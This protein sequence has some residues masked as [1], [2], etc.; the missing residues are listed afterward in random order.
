MYG[1]QLL[2]YGCMCAGARP[3]KRQKHP[4]LT[5]RRELP[6]GGLERPSGA[7]PFPSRQPHKRTVIVMRHSEREDHA[8]AE[9]S[10]PWDPAITEKGVALAR[11]VALERLKALGV[12]KVVCS[13]FLRCLQTAEAIRTALG[14]EEQLVID[15]G[16]AEVFNAQK[17]YTATEPQVLSAAEVRAPTRPCENGSLDCSSGLQRWKSCES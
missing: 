2:P 4:K 14:L 13:P 5:P 8:G 3:G 9:V 7:T 15:N 17:C 12:T 6:E 11:Q 1:W 16:L 10:S